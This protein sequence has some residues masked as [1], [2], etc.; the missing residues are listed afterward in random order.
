M[1]TFSY[2]ENRIAASG[3]FPIDFVRFTLDDVDVSNGAM[4]AELS[5]ETIVALYAQTPSTDT[6]ILRN[7]RTALSAANYLYTKYS[8]QV[9]F[10][11][12]G[13]SMQLSDKAKKFYAAV[14]EG[15]TIQINQLIGISPV[16]YADRPSSYCDG[17]LPLERGWFRYDT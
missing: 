8:K 13:T 4:T 11:S 16:I 15:L 5:D 9:T 6:Q 7:Y 12:A 2:N 10:S 1:S 17:M 3:T 14:I